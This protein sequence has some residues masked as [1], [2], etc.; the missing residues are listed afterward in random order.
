MSKCNSSIQKEK[1]SKK[2]PFLNEKESLA[3][4]RIF[5]KLGI[6]SLAA[7]NVVRR[8]Q[9]WETHHGIKHVVANLKKFYSDLQHAGTTIRK[10]PDGSWRGDFRVIWTLSQKGRRGLSHAARA[11][12]IYGRWEARDVSLKDIAVFK[13]TIETEQP[14][15]SKLES[16][17]LS[18]FKTVTHEDL[19]VGRYAEQE[20]KFITSYPEGSKT[21]PSMDGLLPKERSTMTPRDHVDAAMKFAPNL[22][23]KHHQF[24]NLSCLCPLPPSS[25]VQDTVGAIQGLTKDRGLKV[26]FVANPLLILQLALSRLKDACR[27]FLA[28]SCPEQS[29][30]D[31]ETGAVWVE[32]K[33]REGVRLTSLDLS[34]CSD[35]LPALPQFYL[36][37][38]LFPSL[39]ADIDLFFDVS[40]ANFTIHPQRENIIT[41]WVVGQPLG[42]EPSFFSFTILLLFLVR[43]VGGDARSFRIIGDDLV[44]EAWLTDAM[45]KTYTALGSPI[46]RSKSIVDSPRFAEFAG[47]WIDRYGSLRVFKASPLNLR[48]DPLGYI[49]QYGYKAIKLLPKPYRK[50]LGVLSLYPHP[51]GVDRNSKVPGRLPASVV[52]DVFAAKFKPIPTI[53]AE[54]SPC[55]KAWY[56]QIDENPIDARKSMGMPHWAV[57]AQRLV[58]VASERITRLQQQK[59]W[60]EL[61]FNFQ[62]MDS[63]RGAGVWTGEGSRF[64]DIDDYQRQQSIVLFNSI[65]KGKRLVHHHEP[66]LEQIYKDLSAPSKEPEFYEV[67]RPKPNPLSFYRKVWRKVKSYYQGKYNLLK[68]RTLK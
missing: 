65:V 1:A 20:A 12:K 60:V 11:L 25:E 57:T 39:S 2:K 14:E 41:R 33:L 36:L 66:L 28:Y 4:Q 17:S 53:S 3:I 56:A 37:K 40:R 38:R 16:V 8:M 5:V 18:L 22:L 67:L 64:W 54:P 9:L 68:G 26:R 63:L 32:T 29:V 51:I 24:L 7:Y 13:Q 48:D 10:H 23:R 59:S 62:A 46:N 58:K 61:E 30:F 6:P 49:R 43:S 31:Q 27:T 34:S 45:V 35:L 19:V 21:S 50:M 44:I 52:N 47:R 55:F 42:T 15:H